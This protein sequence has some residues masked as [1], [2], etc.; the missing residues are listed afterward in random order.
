MFCY[1]IH[2]NKIINNMENCFIWLHENLD[3]EF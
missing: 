2:F 3:Y 1:Q